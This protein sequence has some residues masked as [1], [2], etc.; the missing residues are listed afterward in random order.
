LSGDAKG[1]LGA[2][3]VRGRQQLKQGKLAREGWVHGLEIGGLGK[4]APKDGGKEESKRRRN[5]K[6]YLEG[7]PSIL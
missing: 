3:S 1:G 2:W 4:T 6:K 7:S 5:G